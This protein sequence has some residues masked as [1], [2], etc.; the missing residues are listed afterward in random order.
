[1]KEQLQGVESRACDTEIL[2]SCLIKKL[3]EEIDEFHRTNNNASKLV[4]MEVRPHLLF[5]PGLNSRKSPPDPKAHTQLWDRVCCI[6]NSFTVPL[7]FKGTV[8][9]IQKAENYWDT[10]YYVQIGRAHV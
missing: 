3:E 7:G 9:G 4:P 2:N 6:R 10:M 5:I 1:M 8:I